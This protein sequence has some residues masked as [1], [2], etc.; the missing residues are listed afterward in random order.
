MWP[1]PR[2]VAVPGRRPTREAAHE[3]DHA[4]DGRPDLRAAAGARG[5]GERRPRDL[6]GGRARPARLLGEGRRTADLVA[7]VGRGAR[8]EQAALREVVRRRQAQRRLQLPR[9]ARRGRARRPGRL[10]LGGRAGRHPH[11]H[12]RPA[13]RGGLPGRQRAHRARRAGRRPRRHLPADDPRGG[14]LDAGL[15]PHRRRP[16]GGL[17]RV[18]R[19]RAGQ[20]DHR[21]RRRPGHHRRRRLPPR[22]GQRA[23]A[24]RRRRRRPHRG[25]AQ[26]AGGQAH[27]PGRRLDRGPRPLVGRRRGEAVGRAHARGLRRRA[28]ALHHVHVGDDGEAEGDPAHQRRLPHPGRL[29]ALGRLRPEAR[30]RRLLDGGRRRLGDRPQLHRLRA[31]GQPGDERHVRGDAGDAAPRAAGSS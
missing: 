1:E 27:R 12:L 3:R 19:R 5:A 18:L 6:R 10:P 23:E 4:G 26:R 22:R 14:H 16:H 20:P 25:R 13:H 8:L 29:H 15:R 11:V 17:R 30:H 21:R 24:R 7:E 9:P 2:R 31:A 28:P